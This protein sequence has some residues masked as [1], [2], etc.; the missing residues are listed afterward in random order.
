MILFEEIDPIHFKEITTSFSKE[1]FR[2][3]PLSRR[4]KH[5]VMIYKLYSIIHNNNKVG[6]I[7]C[8]KKGIVIE[9]VFAQEICLFILEDYRA[10]GIGKQVLF[11]FMKEIKPSFFKFSKSNIPMSKIATDESKYSKTV[12]NLGK[13]IYLVKR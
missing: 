3:F 9:Q 2:I 12:D 13:P 8:L 4:P 1:Y 11:Q 5:H 10:K 6:Y 7:Y